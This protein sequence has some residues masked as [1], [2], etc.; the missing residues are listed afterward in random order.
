MSSTGLINSKKLITIE[1]PENMLM[2]L[3]NSEALWDGHD[4]YRFEKDGKLPANRK[5]V[6]KLIVRHLKTRGIIK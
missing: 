5:V 4:E 2:L 6:R 1:V 3:V